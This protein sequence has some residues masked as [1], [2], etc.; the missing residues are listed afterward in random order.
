MDGQE[1]LLLQQEDFC[2]IPA[3]YNF[4]MSSLAPATQNDL[5]AFPVALP[6]GEYRVGLLDS[7]PDVRLLMGYCAFG[8]PDVALLVS[9]L[10]RFVL[11][12]GEKRLSAL[13]EFVGEEARAKRPARDVVLA[14]LME[15]LLIEALRSTGDTAAS[16]GL[17]QGLADDR[18][19]VALRRIHERPAYSWTVALLANEAALSRSVFFERF[20]RAVGVAPMEYVLAWR[21]ALAKDMLRRKE[22]NVAEVAERVGYKSPSTFSVAFTRHVGMPP[23]QYVQNARD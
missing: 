23:S 9:L 19:A 22:G 16:P 3:A 5:I 12:R 2:L 17:L 1:S 8:S 7:L 13:V 11:V 18:L 21:M 4:T 20:R 6:N 14:H 15:V 10:P